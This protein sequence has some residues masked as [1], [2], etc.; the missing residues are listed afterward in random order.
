MRKFVLRQIVMVIAVG[1]AM[2]AVGESA[3]NDVSAKPETA[4]GRTDFNATDRL[5]ILNLIHAYA[6]EV[7]RLNLDAWFDLFTRDAIF[8]DRVPGKADEEQSGEEF[9]KFGRQRFGS[10]KAG[11]NQRGH[12]ISNI[13]FVEQTEDTAHTVMEA[14]LTNT[15]DGK[16][17]R[18]VPGI[19]Y[20][21]WF[22]KSKGGVWKI[23]RWIDAADVNF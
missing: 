20:E 13:V 7:D 1:W 19:N 22:V 18:A 12:L 8:V 4:A 23:K 3:G 21:G 6:V 9:H 16:I 17:L 14:L 10:L 2:A 11:G 5:A 15:K